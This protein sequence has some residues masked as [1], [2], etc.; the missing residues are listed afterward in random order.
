MSGFFAVRRPM[1]LV[2]T[3]SLEHVEEFMKDFKHLAAMTVQEAVSWF[4]LRADPCYTDE[5][6][7]LLTSFATDFLRNAGKDILSLIQDHECILQT[8]ALI[9]NELEQ[10]YVGFLSYLRDLFGNFN[11]SDYRIVRFVG[12]RSVVISSKPLI[13]YAPATFTF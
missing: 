9:R 1:G 6:D 4:F 3:L 12:C 11:T 2:G 7:S 13:A 5:K 8:R 10:I